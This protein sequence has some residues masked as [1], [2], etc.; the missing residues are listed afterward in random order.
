[1]VPADILPNPNPLDLVP[2]HG[3]WQ[4]QALREIDRVRRA[5]GPAC[6]AV[7]HIGST[8]VPGLHAVSVID[9]LAELHAP[10]L[11]GPVLL[12]LMAHGFTPA[13][14]APPCAL[15][16]AYDAMTGHRR[17][18]LHCYPARHADA[19]LL[20]AFFA[21]LRTAPAAA[22]AYDHM[23]REARTRHG[24]ASPAYDAA[25]RAWVRQHAATPAGQP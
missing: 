10:D 18:E 16:I 24:P 12:R 3:R 6:H 19:Q 9:L 17:V 22:A 5:L 14:A 8:S 2:P 25:K 7:H 13:Q 21:H 4:A 1:M 11:S 23:K 20:I 15:H